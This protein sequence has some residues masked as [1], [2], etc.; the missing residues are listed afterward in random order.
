[1]WPFDTRTAAARLAVAGE[2]AHLFDLWSHSA[3]RESVPSHRLGYLRPRHTS[4]RRPRLPVLQLLVSAGES[5]DFADPRT[6][7]TGLRSAPAPE[8]VLTLWTDDLLSLRHGE[9][10]I[11]VVDAQQ[12]FPRAWLR[13]LT[14]HGRAGR[15]PYARR[16]RRLRGADCP[17]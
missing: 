15:P 10:W 2:S 17:R 16:D 13:L 5:I 6:G 8:R 11:Y 3:H 9:D 14:P 7:F 4:V 1:M 12:P